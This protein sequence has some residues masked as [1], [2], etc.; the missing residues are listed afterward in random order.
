MPASRVDADQFAAA[1]NLA[2]HHLEAAV[3]AIG[4][5]IP[6]LTEDDRRGLIKPA[7][8]FPEAAL[9]MVEVLK[10]F[11]Q[12]MQLARFDPEAVRE[13]LANVSQLARLRPYLD[14]LARLTSDGRLAWL[15]EV[16]TAAY[17]A[18]GI[19][20]SLG[21]ADPEAARVWEALKPIFS[22]G[23]PKSTER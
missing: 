16:A 7:D 14:H 19:A 20:R 12:I 13:D 2:I 4:P 6:A 3:Q 22:G 9:R 15:D 5:F 1:T 21:D 10:G 11:P 23:R 18:N 17:L 8:A